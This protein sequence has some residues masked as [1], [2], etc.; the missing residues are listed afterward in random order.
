MHSAFPSPVRKP[1]ILFLQNCRDHSTKWISPWQNIHYLLYMLQNESIAEESTEITKDSNAVFLGLWACRTPSLQLL[2]KIAWA[3]KICT[4]YSLMCSSSV[5]RFYLIKHFHMNGNVKLQVQSCEPWL[6]T[7]HLPSSV[8]TA[9]LTHFAS[10]NHG[11]KL[12]ALGC[13]IPNQS[14]DE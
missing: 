1:G 8:F 5:V 10:A 12:N 7:P 3:L 4:R 11:E 6:T 13:T 14:W 2:Y 9:L